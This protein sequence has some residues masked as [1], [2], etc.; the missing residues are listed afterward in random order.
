MKKAGLDP[1]TIVG[2][3]ARCGEIDWRYSG[4]KKNIGNL[5]YGKIDSVIMSPPYSEGIGH[6]AGEKASDEHKK[7][8]EY[9]RRQTEG[10]TEGNIAKMKHGDIDAI[11]TSPPY[12]KVISGGKEGPNAT[13]DPDLWEREFRG[14][15]RDKDQKGFEIAYSNDKSNIGNLKGQTYLE[16]MH[17]VYAECF[18]VLKKGGYMVLV[19]KNFI[20]NKKI[21]DLAG[22][23][24]KLCESVGFKH[25]RTHKR[26]LTNHSFWVINYR[27]R[28]PDA[29]A[30]RVDFEHVLV[31]Q[32]V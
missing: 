20:R 12:E 17:Q 22:D 13:S 14:K 30:P 8:L 29:P 16:A 9:Q 24:V 19:V 28:Y 27:K 21:V 32:K 3:K 5:K 31:F 1:K 26:K 10:W 4:D 2:G 11:V 6:V 7:R 15:H 23:T 18:K 25:V